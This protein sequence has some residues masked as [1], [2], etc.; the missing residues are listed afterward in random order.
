MG[1][2][3]LVILERS[4]GLLDDV[5]RRC[6]SL[7]VP[8]CPR[9]LRAGARL[10]IRLGKPERPDDLRITAHQGFDKEK[11]WPIGKGRRLDADLKPVKRDGERVA[12]DVF[13]FVTEPNRDYYLGF[14][15]M[16]GEEP[17]THVS[18][19]HVSGG[20]ASYTFHVK[21]RA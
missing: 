19:T 18:G 5:L 6:G 2:F 17:G 10:H 4:Q 20:D 8:P 11:K 13:F 9:P 12:W 3:L 14:Y 21:T 15:S 7:R 16:W 1:F